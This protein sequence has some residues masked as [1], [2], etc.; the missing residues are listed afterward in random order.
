MCNVRLRAGIFLLLWLLRELLDLSPRSPAF[1]SLIGSMAKKADLL[2]TELCKWAYLQ[3]GSDSSA[4]KSEPRHH[5]LKIGLGSALSIELLILC[6][7]RT[8]KPEALP[9]TRKSLPKSPAADATF[10]LQSFALGPV[11]AI[12]FFRAWDFKA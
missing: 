9:L 7:P 4:G 10:A 3:T 12:E 2:T 1:S 11:R 5:Q 8:P 6:N